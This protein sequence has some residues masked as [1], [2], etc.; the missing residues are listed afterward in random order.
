VLIQPDD[1]TV[2]QYEDDNN[3]LL[4]TK[5]TCT[6]SDIDRTTQARTD[7]S[8][9][10]NYKD[11]NRNSPLIPLINKPVNNVNVT[12]SSDDT[13]RTSAVSA[14]GRRSKLGSTAS[15]VLGVVVAVL[16]MCADALCREHDSVVD[17]V[18]RVPL[19]LTLGKS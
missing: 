1:A 3:Q 10:L 17:I 7:S 13:Q 12:S 16:A 18:V 11:S 14:E 9:R 2:C 8:N 6:L 5:H 19:S 15:V 4:S